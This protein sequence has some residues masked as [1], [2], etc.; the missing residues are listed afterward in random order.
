MKIIPTSGR[1]VLQK[2]KEEEKPQ[3]L[4]IV[5]NSAPV[6]AKYK[7]V[8]APAFY[9]DTGM[10]LNVGDVVYIDKYKAME[11]TKDGSS[12]LVI[13]EEDVIAYEAG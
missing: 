5:P 2:I 3:G 11:I 4:V 8:A 6:Q 7:I 9:I 12:Y 13:K 10:R 1:L